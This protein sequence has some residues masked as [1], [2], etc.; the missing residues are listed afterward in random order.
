MPIP[1]L[2]TDK[3]VSMRETHSPLE[4]VKDSAERG[5]KD[6]QEYANAARDNGQTGRIILVSYSH[7]VKMR[8]FQKN[9][10]KYN[11]FK[12]DKLYKE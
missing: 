8:E 6:I 9:G 4:V 1:L 2:D 5:V 11:I 7:I 12:Y 10:M 3:Y